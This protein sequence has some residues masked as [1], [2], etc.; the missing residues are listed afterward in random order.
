MIAY[1]WTWCKR[2]KIWTGQDG[3]SKF[4]SPNYSQQKAPATSFVFY[5]FVICHLF[6]IFSQSN[7]TLKNKL[8]QE[9][10]YLRKSRIRLQ[11]LLFT[12]SMLMC[13]FE[14][15]ILYR[16]VSCLFGIK[17]L[18]CNKRIELWYDDFIHM[19]LRDILIGT[20]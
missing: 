3:R 5:I 9:V 4:H 7:V 2:M 8:W 6:L 11:S 19:F 1:R 20:I 15:F 12:Y 17:D 16:Y 13:C 18:Y 14:L 10:V